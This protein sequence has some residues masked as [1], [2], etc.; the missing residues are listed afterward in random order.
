M[1]RAFCALPAFHHW[2]RKDKNIKRRIIEY[3]PSP[4]KQNLTRRLYL[5]ALTLWH[6]LWLPTCLV[7]GLAYD[8]LW[9]VQH[10]K[11]YSKTA[12]RALPDAGRAGRPLWMSA[13]AT[14]AVLRVRSI[15]LL[16]TF[17]SKSLH[18]LMYHWIIWLWESRYLIKK[19]AY[20][21]SC[22]KSVWQIKSS[23][24]NCSVLCRNCLQS[25]KNF[26]SI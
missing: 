9:S 23:V 2:K 20:E 10:R 26:N 15:F 14:S 18:F 3:K 4:G 22:S 24:W 6:S 8:V 7:G 21:T 11:A 13:T 19:K 5:C 17:S 16:L 12:Q 25:L 1:H